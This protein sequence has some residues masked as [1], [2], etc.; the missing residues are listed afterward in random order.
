MQKINLKTFNTH[1]HKENFRKE[2]IEGNF[3]TLIKAIYQKHR[4]SIIFNGKMLETIYLN[5][6]KSKGP[7]STAPFGILL[8]TL[9]NPSRQGKEKR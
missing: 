5:S 6:G 8:K 4:G 3:L 9:T 2:G 7:T 1:L